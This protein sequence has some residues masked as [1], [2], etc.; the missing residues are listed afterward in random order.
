MR[1]YFNSQEQKSGRALRPRLQTPTETARLRSEANR[2]KLSALVQNDIEWYKQSLQKVYDL[3]LKTQVGDLTATEY[4]LESVK[5]L[6][7]NLENFQQHH[8]YQILEELSSEIE[9]Y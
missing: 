1:N 7:E 8:L 9:S 4:L 6:L 5:N 3:Y 2:Q